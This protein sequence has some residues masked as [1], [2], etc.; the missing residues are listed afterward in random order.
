[1]AISLRQI[2]GLVQPITGTNPRLAQILRKIAGSLAVDEIVGAKEQEINRYVSI[3]FELPGVQVIASDI[4]PTRYT[5]R[6]PRDIVNNLLVQKIQ[7]QL[8]SISAKVTGAADFIMDCL[9]SV[10]K[11]ANFKSLFGQDNSTKPTIPAGLFLIKNTFFSIDQLFDED[12]LRIDCI[13]TGTD[14]D[15]I[16][17]YLIGNYVD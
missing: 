14:W 16:E 11:G 2:D 6:L 13:V 10:D 7:L 1:M 9:V 8:I 12:M 17:F 5:I 4:L 15:G 3:R